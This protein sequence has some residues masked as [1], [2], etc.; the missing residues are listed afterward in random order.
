MRNASNRYLTSFGRLSLE[1]QRVTGPG[2][3]TTGLAAALATTMP[4]RRIKNV[5]RPVPPF[6]DGFIDDGPTPQFGWASCSARF[7]F[8]LLIAVPNARN[9]LLSRAPSGRRKWLS[10]GARRRPRPLGCGCCCRVARAVRDRRGSLV[11]GLATG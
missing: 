6:R 9:R 2:E 3:I 8:V 10:L 11:L 4:E 1:R 7:S 5:L